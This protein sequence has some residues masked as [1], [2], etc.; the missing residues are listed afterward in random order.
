MSAQL[1]FGFAAPR[2]ID[3]TIERLSKIIDEATE[4]Q[5]AQLGATAAWPLV[6]MVVSVRAMERGEEELL[7]TAR[8]APMAD[9][10]DQVVTPGEPAHEALI[11]TFKAA[12]GAETSA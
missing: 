12:Y 9:A 10:Y 11:K 3:V 7:G 8:P 2:R 4:E 1:E 5:R 6:K